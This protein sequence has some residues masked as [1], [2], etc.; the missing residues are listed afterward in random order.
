MQSPFLKNALIYR[1]NPHYFKSEI[2]YLGFSVFE[3]NTNGQY[4]GTFLHP[5]MKRFVPDEKM[6]AFREKI[7]SAA[8]IL[9]KALKKTVYAM[10]HRGFLGIDALIFKHEGKL[11]LQPCIEINSRMNMGILAMFLENK[12]YPM[13]LEIWTLLWKFRKV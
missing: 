2:D 5:D 3:T 8:E 6:T 11:K 1:S 12:I 4:Q 7:E 10:E 13:Q 9:C